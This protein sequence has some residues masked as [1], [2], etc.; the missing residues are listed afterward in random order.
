[1]KKLVLFFTCLGLFFSCNRPEIGTGVSE[2]FFVRTEGADMPVYVRG[3]TSSNTFI[4]MI[5]GGP[6]GEAFS[7]SLA[8]FSDILEKDYGMLFW[9]Q[10]GQGAS[11][12]NY[13]E[14]IISIDRM[15]QDLQAVVLAIQERYGSEAK[16]YLMGHSW[17]GLLGT[18]YVQ[19]EDQAQIDGWIEVAGAHDLPLLYRSAY[20]M[21]DSVADVE[22]LAG[23]DTDFWAEVK[24]SLAGLPPTN[25]I[26]E[27]WLRLNRLGHRSEQTHP[28]IERDDIARVS[29][30]EAI[31][32]NP[33]DPVSAG[34][35][36]L[37]TANLLLEEV[38]Q[39]NLSPT[40]DQIQVPTLLLWGKYDF[41]VPP[42]LGETAFPLI[43]SSDKEYYLFEHSGHSPMISEPDE[44]AKVVKDWVERH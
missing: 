12:G 8:K 2:T 14:D 28:E 42:R 25:F 35:S 34:F 24:D 27:E 32:S 16:L 36:G 5:H 30:G 33:I 10:R 20:T 18:A 4:M 41:I 13:S 1:M 17:G 37:Q 3:N 22:L 9:D 7:Y 6:G 44:F 15:R 26:L 40:M 39:T 19:S 23:R 31:F 29:L 11:Q 43:G 38:S 21:L